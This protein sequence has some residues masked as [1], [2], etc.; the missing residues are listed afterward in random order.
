MRALSRLW[1]SSYARLALFTSIATVVAYTIGL[2][3]PYVDPIPAAITA[4]VATRA[5]FHHAAKETVF[6]I[7]G[8]LM[9]ATIALIIVSVLGTGPLVIFL[10]VLLCFAL[11]RWLRLSSPQ[12]SPF[13]AAGMA[14]TVI[15]V[16][17]THL[18]TELAIERFTGVVVGALCALGASAL[19]APSKDTRVLLLDLESLKDELAGL[20]ALMSEGLRHAPDRTVA[21][22]W[23]ET[24]IDLR[25]RTIGLAARWEELARNRRWSPRI[26][27]DDLSTLKQELDA[28]TVMS[29]RL[30]SIASDLSSAASREAAPLPPA[31]ATPLADLM[32]MAAANIAA[33]DPTAALGRT[34]AHEA[35]RVA[36][37]TAQIAL[38]GGIVSNLNRINQAASDEDVT[39]ELPASGAT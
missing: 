15:L 17:G 10:L 33:D 22:Q 19:T 7:L 5:T 4:A 27:P 12:D 29:S 26:D 13:V 28:T 35:V 32:A 37:Q 3:A 30:L 31:A 24:A 21:R 39:G 6:Q 38:I 2:V 11:A 34:Q 8:A 16:V 25:N 14:V 18:T 23:R 1:A 36:E 9:G 20:L